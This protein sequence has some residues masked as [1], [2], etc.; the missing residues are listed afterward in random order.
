MYICTL[1]IYICYVEY[2]GHLNALYQKHSIDAVKPKYCSGFQ[3][4]EYRPVTYTDYTPH[5]T[6]YTIT[7]HIV[8]STQ[9]SIKPGMHT[10]DYLLPL[11]IN[12]KFIYVPSLYRCL[13]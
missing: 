8:G 10:T 4:C 2:Q 11:R 5:Y 7:N 9:W 6:P 13:P 12:S 3:H 1:T